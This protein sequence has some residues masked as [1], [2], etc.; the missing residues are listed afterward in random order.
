MNRLS[1]ESFVFSI[2]FLSSIRWLLKFQ[3]S[4]LAF[5]SSRRV[6]VIILFIVL[7]FERKIW[8]KTTIFRKF[9]LIWKSNGSLCKINWKMANW[10]TLKSINLLY[11]RLI[12]GISTTSAEK[13]KVSLNSK[14]MQRKWDLVEIWKLKLDLVKF[15]AKLYLWRYGFY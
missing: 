2:S 15:S 1:S 7:Q 5:L 3:S 13:F 6:S 4:P 11:I 12:P 8:R 9:W 14:F 10:A